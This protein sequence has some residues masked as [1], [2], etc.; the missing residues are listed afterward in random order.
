MTDFKGYGKP[1]RLSY[2]YTYKCAHC[3]DETSGK[4]KRECGKCGSPMD[5]SMRLPYEEPTDPQGPAYA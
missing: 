3:G 2:T 4:A 5:K 1:R